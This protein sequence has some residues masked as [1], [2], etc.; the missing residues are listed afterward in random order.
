MNFI[1]A[2]LES[3]LHHVNQLSADSKPE[4][5]SMTAQKMIE[6]LTDA[7]RIGNGQ[8]QLECI[9]EGERL[10]RSRDFLLSEAPMPKGFKAVYV[11]DDAA[12]RNK[13]FE[14]AVDELTEAWVD[15]EEQCERNP[16]VKHTHPV[17]GD[18]TPDEWRWMHR[19]HFTHHLTQ[20]GVQIERLEHLED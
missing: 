10:Q 1:E 20:F 3:I 2:N 19:K 11:Q 9:N 15:F 14:L 16:V 4:W 17:F 8:I 6:H 12:L 13:E 18:L 7:V 5:G